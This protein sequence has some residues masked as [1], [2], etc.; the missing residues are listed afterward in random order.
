MHA[1]WHWVYKLSSQLHRGRGRTSCIQFHHC[2][3]PKLHCRRLHFSVLRLSMHWWHTSGTETCKYMFLCFPNW[4]TVSIQQIQFASNS[5]RSV[6]NFS[7]VMC[8]EIA[9]AHTSWGKEQERWKLLMEEQQEMKMLLCGLSSRNIL[10]W[11][12]TLFS[13]KWKTV[14]DL[15]GMNLVEWI[16]AAGSHKAL[17]CWKHTPWWEKVTV[18]LEL[19]HALVA[20]F[21]FCFSSKIL[22]SS[23][24]L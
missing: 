8:L 24:V 1:D 20:R 18:L 4:Q 12:R 15:H 21:H 3:L 16:P 7:L 13:S 9:I 14:A 6:Q 19:F 10:T 22:S 11:C 23:L 17:Q 2:R 5:W